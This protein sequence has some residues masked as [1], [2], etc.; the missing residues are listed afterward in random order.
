MSILSTSECNY[1]RCIRPNRQRTPDLFDNDYVISQLKAA[2]IMEA[3]D[4]TRRG[5]A[6][7]L[8]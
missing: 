2:G 6:S 3:I 8:V 7:K 5:F 1:I 4:V